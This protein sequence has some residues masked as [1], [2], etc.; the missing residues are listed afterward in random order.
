MKIPKGASKGQ[1]VQCLKKREQKDKQWSA[2]H[3]TE[4]EI[5]YKKNTR[6]P[7][8]AGVDSCVSESS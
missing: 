6:S 8:R 5:R 1:I 7:L 2:K 4:N 3:D